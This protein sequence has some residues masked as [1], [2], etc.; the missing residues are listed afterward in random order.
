MCFT[1]VVDT[2]H[3]ERI[4]LM[5]EPSKIVLK[6]A[7]IETSTMHMVEARIVLICPRVPAA[8]ECGSKL[9]RAK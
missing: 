4:R 9:Q 2:V 1:L 6:Y 5:I 8:F 7:M 3:D